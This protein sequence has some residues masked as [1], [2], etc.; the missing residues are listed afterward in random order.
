M[1]TAVTRHLPTE[2]HVPIRAL[3]VE[4]LPEDADLIAVSLHRAG[5]EPSWMRVDTAQQLEKALL[6]KWDLVIA[7]FNMPSFSGADALE[8]VRVHAPDLPFILVSGTATDEQAIDVMRA[9]ANDYLSKDKLIRLGPAVERELRDAETRR[10]RRRAEASLRFL[11]EASATLA[12][13]SLEYAPTLAQVASLAVPFLAQACV[14]DLWEDGQLVRVGSAHADPAKTH[15]LAEAVP[16]SPLTS[17]VARS[18]A[19]LLVR[20]V[21]S[22]AGAAALGPA[23]L[24][25]LSALGIASMISVPLTTAGQT[26]GAMGFGSGARRY[27]AADLALAQELARRA[28]VAIH[29]AQLFLAAGEAIR[30]RD[31]FIAI[32]AHELRTPL[33]PLRLQIEGIER[34]LVSGSDVSIAQFRP[35]VDAVARAAVRLGKLVESLLDVSRAMRDQLE[36]A[37]TVA[38]LARIVRD[39]AD[40][41][42]PDA[43]Q[44]GSALSVDVC[45]PVTGTWDPARIDQVVTNLLSNAIRYGCGKPID[46]S[47]ERAGDLATI[48]VR[49]HGIGISPADRARIF[50]RFERAVSGRHFG[51][52]GIGLWIA[53]RIV[54]AHG[55]WIEVDSEPGNG[56]TFSVCLP[57]QQSTIH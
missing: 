52:L 14:V 48:R 24:A 27:D 35:R 22:E 34:L 20:D 32:A 42:A 26:V 43:A 1:S 36:L 31:E 41:L 11:A 10:A 51:G 4:D 13:Q 56:S 53:R 3:I 38:D 6:D 5:Y 33:T 45:E 37:P 46:V 7:D 18:G 19:P 49:D 9:G 50:E 17:L 55:G 29:N 15:A 21:A 30:K 40:R 16:D 57:S 44:H 12:S 39:A 54:E 28:G 8:I 2:T 47:V 23:M 25:R